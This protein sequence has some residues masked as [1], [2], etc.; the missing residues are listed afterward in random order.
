MRYTSLISST[1]TLTRDHVFGGVAMR[2]GDR[3]LMPL[4]L[5]NRDPEV[6]EGA[7]EV[8]FDRKSNTHLAFGSGP[9]RCLGSHLARVEMVVAMEE[10]FARVPRFALDPND[11]PVGHGGHAMG[12]SRLPLVWAP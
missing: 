6:F 9:H 7:D 4:R 5:A 11:P 1:R 8:R 10:W 2:K 12:L 3:V